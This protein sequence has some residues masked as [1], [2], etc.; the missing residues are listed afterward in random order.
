MVLRLTFGGRVSSRIKAGWLNPLTLVAAGVMLAPTV[1]VMVNNFYVH[2]HDTVPRLG[3][4]EIGVTFDYTSFR[5]VLALPDLGLKGPLGRIDGVLPVLQRIDWSSAAEL[6]A[7]TQQL[8]TKVPAEVIR[9]ITSPLHIGQERRRRQTVMR[10]PFEVPFTDDKPAARWSKGRPTL[11]DL[12][13]L[14]ARLSK[15]EFLTELDGRHSELSG[16]LDRLAAN[17]ID[18]VDDDFLLLIDR[19]VVQ[20]SWDDRGRLRLVAPS[21]SSPF[22][23]ARLEAMSAYSDGRP[24]LVRCDICDRWF[25]PVRAGRPSRRCPGFDCRAEAEKRYQNSPDRREYRRLAMRVS[26]ARNKGDRTALREAEAD[27]EQFKSRR[28]TD[29]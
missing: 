4:Q 7:H 11:A 12:E 25:V 29:D 18:K 3:T 10:P 8:G 26:R 2:N 21:F 9:W 13:D 5:L 16:F 24:G 6:H 20:Y 14:H 22:D 19:L 28:S 15:S 1:K 27:L 17:G 23:R